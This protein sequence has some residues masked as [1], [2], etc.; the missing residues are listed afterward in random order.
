MTHTPARFS[1]PASVRRMAE[2]SSKTQ[3]A[4]PPMGFFDCFSSGLR[5]PPC[6]RCTTNQTDSKPHEQVL[7]PAADV[8]E[9]FTDRVLG[10]R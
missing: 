1:L 9:R 2:P 8:L 3:R 5:R 10:G 7:A 4:S 6:I